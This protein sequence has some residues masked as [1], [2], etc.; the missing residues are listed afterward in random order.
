MHACK[1]FITP[2]TDIPQAEAKLKGLKQKGSLS[3]HYSNFV[4]AAKA[5]DWP[6]DAGSTRQ[7]FKDTLSP[8]LHRKL[9]QEE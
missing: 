9:K 8:N 4:E 3:A 2:L 1:M 7:K 6:L 5:A